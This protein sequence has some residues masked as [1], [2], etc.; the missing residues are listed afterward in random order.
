MKTLMLHLIPILLVS[1]ATPSDPGC[2]YYYIGSALDEEGNY[3]TIE[4]PEM[5]C[6]DEL[7]KGWPIE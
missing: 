2:A 3:D 5:G 7:G 6:E 1:C 4:V